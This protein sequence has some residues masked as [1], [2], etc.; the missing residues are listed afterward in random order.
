MVD[1]Q[2]EEMVEDIWDAVEHH[3]L[4]HPNF[5]E[6]A[7][8]FREFGFVPARRLVE[9]EIRRNGKVKGSLRFE[10]RGG[11]MERSRNSVRQSQGGYSS[12]VIGGFNSNTNSGP[13]QSNQILSESRR[14]YQNRR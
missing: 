8:G 1:R 3:S 9:D 13:Y 14:S 6:E 11:V 10:D 12:R 5:R 2:A 4:L 7:N